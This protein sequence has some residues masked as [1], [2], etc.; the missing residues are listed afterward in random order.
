MGRGELSDRIRTYNWPND[1]ITDHRLN[2]TKFG[3][4]SMLSGKLLQEF[5]EELRTKERQEL[6]SAI[7]ES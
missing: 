2:E 5:I 6:V 3:I 4:E 7:L 1:R